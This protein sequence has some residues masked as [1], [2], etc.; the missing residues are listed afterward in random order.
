MTIPHK[1]NS[2]SVLFSHCCESL[3]TI[4]VYRYEFAGNDYRHFVKI[5]HKP[6]LLWSVSTQYD[7]EELQ[8]I[9][10][11]RLLLFCCY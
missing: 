3:Y 4:N 7:K 2:T 5:E 8:L 11:V 9:N 6:L 1:Q 10:T